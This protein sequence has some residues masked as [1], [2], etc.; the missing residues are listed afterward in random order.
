[1]DEVDLLLDTDVLVDLLR[2]FPPAVR[3]AKDHASARLGIPVVVYLEL[4]QGARHQADLDA[5]C[6]YLTPYPILH[7]E[8]GDST[9]ALECFKEHRL[10][11]GIGSRSPIR[12]T[13]EPEPPAP[14]VRDRHHLPW[15]IF[16]VACQTP[17]SSRY[18]YT[19]D[20]TG[21]PRSFRPSHGTA[22]YSGVSRPLT[23]VDWQHPRPQ[24]DTLVLVDLVRRLAPT[25]ARAA[26]WPPPASTSHWLGHPQQVDWRRWRAGTPTVGSAPSFTGSSR[27]SDH[28]K[29]RNDA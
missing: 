17:A 11:R 23:V 12:G 3:W 5:L 21:A 1:M 10:S 7:L 8:S 18:R 19:P 26:G 6:R 2:R 29:S 20:E 28:G 25:I 4:L 9:R 16:P 22:W 27:G 24:P 14:C 13:R 15:A